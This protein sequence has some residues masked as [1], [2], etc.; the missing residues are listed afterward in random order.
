VHATPR[1]P[2]SPGPAHFPDPKV[3]RTGRNEQPGYTMYPRLAELEKFKVPAPGTY[4]TVPMSITDTRSPAYSFGLNCP[5]IEG[6][7]TPGRLYMQICILPHSYITLSPNLI[8][9]NTMYIRHS[10]GTFISHLKVY[11]QYRKLTNGL[12]S[13]S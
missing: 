11:D 10:Y 4:T 3:L 9:L 2:C 7:Q 12:E 1:D 5:P 13:K 8:P 6:D